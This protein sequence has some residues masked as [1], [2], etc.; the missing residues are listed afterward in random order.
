MNRILLDP[1]RY[2]LA[3]TLIFISCNA[4][5]QGA[6]EEVVVTATK[7]VESIQ[8]V[9]VSVSALD[10]DTMRANG[11]IDMASASAYI[12]GF[13]YSEST[14]LPNLYVRGIGSG[15]THS[16]EQSVGRFVD[17]V[18]IGR[19]AINLHGFMDMAS[20]EVL[21]GPQGTLFGKNTL[22]G[23]MIMRTANPT[24]ELEVGV[25]VKI[26]DYDTTGGVIQVDGFVSGPISDSV[27][28]R[29]AVQY[30][31]RDGYVENLA[32]GPDGGTREDWGVRGKLE[33]DVTN[34]TTALLKVEH[35]EYDE[36]GQIDGE[37]VT[38]G[39]LPLAFW[40]SFFPQFSF[41]RNWQQFQDCTAQLGPNN[42]TFCPGRDQDTQN[43]TLKIEHE[44]EGLGTIT[45]VSAYQQ[46][47]YLHHFTALD[48][49][50]L[51]G[52][53]RA[54]RNETYE[55]FTQEIRLTSE[56]FDKFDYIVGA[57]YENSDLERLQ[58]SDFQIPLLFGFPK[59]APCNSAN[60]ASPNFIGF[61]P[62]CYT[63]REDWTQD[64]ET[65]AV[66]GE[67][68]YRITDTITAIAGGR[69][70]TED[71]HYI[72][73]DAIVDYQDDPNPFTHD[74][75]DLKR[76]E[77]KFTPSVTLQWEATD[78]MMLYANFSQGHK[79]GGF[80]DRVQS[81]LE[82]DDELNTSYEVGLKGVWLNDTVRAN[83]AFFY[84]DIED[85]QLS[86]TIPGQAIIFEVD[87]AGEATSLG[88]EFEG[89]WL[90]HENW[91]LGGNLAYT[92]AEFDDFPG[93]APTCPPA[94]GVI[95]NGV[96]NFKGLPLIFAPEWKGSAYLNFSAGNVI[97]TWGVN[98]NVSTSFS[99][100]YYGEINYFEVVKQRSYATVDASLRVSSA[101]DKYAIT[102]LAKNLTDRY[103][104]AWG[105]N[106]A[107]VEWTVPNPPR[108]IAVQFSYR[109]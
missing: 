30:K 70:S 12:P 32:P 18:Y 98:A 13:E 23:A 75:F 106:S 28:G 3:A 65:F 69:W 8:D 63:D 53:L 26:S 27:R 90:F 92:D 14:I 76:S 57:Y 37:L 47:E 38:G 35:R 107:F 52:A 33:W 21:R 77:N 71:K 74:L 104:Q 91:T 44:I 88:V 36:K 49:G 25:D 102:V 45:S 109:Y 5:S 99:S 4:V 40:Q 24:D 6:L 29:I 64:T 2:I 100:D 48:F 51:G 43:Y 94:G 72:F 39:P 15:T 105:Q 31:D 79:T 62:P 11:I 73:E 103:T 67:L 10:A 7:R 17:E 81:S 96:C 1:T 78:E 84:M 59:N 58:S 97:G 66:F 101:D 55:G 82:F 95:E 93:A 20:V 68:R 108:E 16:I 86:R 42:E 61:G 50:I 89:T 56:K 80:A 22:G 83:L 46:Y 85:L 9:P 34:N 54:T 60:P 41:D 19:A 87:N